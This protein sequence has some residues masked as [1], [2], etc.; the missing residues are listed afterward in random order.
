MIELTVPLAEGGD[1]SGDPPA[2]RRYVD[3]VLPVGESDYS[4]DI[5]FRGNRNISK[6]TARLKM[7]S[8]MSSLHRFRVSARF[9]DGSARFSKPLTLFYLKPRIPSV[10]SETDDQACYLNQ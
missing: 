9:T 5:P 2:A 1:F 4:I 7:S 8:H 10:P 3:I 6:Y